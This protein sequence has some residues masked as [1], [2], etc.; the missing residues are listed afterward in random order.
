MRAAGRPFD[1]WGEMEETYHFVQEFKPEL[2][3]AKLE[4]AT[5]ER[6]KAHAYRQPAPTPCRAT[7][8][9]VSRYAAAGPG[10]PTG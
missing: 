6:N 2:F 10:G 8:R 4:E 3:G 7:S 1:K 9:V 5:A